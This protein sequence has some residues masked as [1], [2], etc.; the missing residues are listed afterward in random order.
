[1][2]FY[3]I[4]LVSCFCLLATTALTAQDASQNYHA[5]LELDGEPM[6]K[7]ISL[8]VTSGSSEVSISVNGTVAG[9]NLKVHLYDPEG[10]RIANLNLCASEGSKAKGSLSETQD[11]SPGI[12]KLKID[13]YGATGKVNINFSQN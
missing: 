6:Q 3:K 2:K 4:T 9:G 10:N 7:E 11:A 5:K 8:T 12:W 13:K 1:M